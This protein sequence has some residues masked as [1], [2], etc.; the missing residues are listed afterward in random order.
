MAY[1]VKQN[2]ASSLVVGTLAASATT[3]NVTPGEEPIFLHH[4]LSY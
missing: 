3:L 4:F 1:Y 2:N